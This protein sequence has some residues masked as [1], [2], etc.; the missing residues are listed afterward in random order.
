MFYYDNHFVGMHLLWWFVWVMLIFWIFATPY[1]VPGIQK[2]KSSPLDILKRRLAAG[3][4]SK[5]DYQE[6]KRMLEIG[7]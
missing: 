7:N 3:E 4:I 1:Y 2:I 5:E 6:N